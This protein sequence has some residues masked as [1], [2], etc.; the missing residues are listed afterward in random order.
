[1][2]CIL[3]R[4]L[5]AR[6]VLENLNIEAINHSNWSLHILTVWTAFGLGGRGHLSGSKEDLGF[7]LF[8]FIAANRLSVAVVWL[9]Q[10]GRK[11]IS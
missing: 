10:T 2:H 1:M 9:D 6:V 5:L 8:S 7:V 11:M 4:S 3:G